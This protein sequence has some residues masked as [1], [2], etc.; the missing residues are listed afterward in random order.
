MWGMS[1]RPRL[2]GW[3]ACGVL[4]AASSV[5]RAIGSW[6]LA[7]PWIAPDEPTYGMLG[8]SLWQAGRL[9]ILGVEGPFYGLVYPAFA[10][11]PLTVL[12][13]AHGLRALQVIQP[14]VMST[15][16]LLVY[17]WARRLVSA[18]LALVAAALT[19]AVPAFTYS[20]LIM[21]EA[22][23]YPVATLA[24]LAIARA[25]EY[26]S[27]ARQAVAA[28]AILLAT[29]TR[30]Q[31]LVL[32]P[33]LITAVVL[34]AI[35]ERSTRPLRRF[36]VSLAL[37]CV[38][39]AIVLVVDHAGASKDVLG[40]YTTVARSSYELGPA[41]HWMVWHAADVF[42]LVAGVPFL[43]AVA[44]FVEAARGRE[45]SPAARALLAV[46]VASTV[47]L[48]AQVGVFSSRF[49]G[50][51][52][53][54]NLVT[55]APPLFVA[56]ALWLERGAPRPQPSTAVACVLAIVPA[57]A[58]PPARLTDPASEPS[59]FTALAFHHLHDWTSLDST[60]AVWVVAVA[61]LTSLFLSLP[62]RA[63][64]SLAGIALTLLIGASVV[65]S[66]DVHRLSGQLHRQLFAD[67][68]PRWIDQRADGPVAYLYGGNF[69]WNGVWM[70]VFWNTRIDQVFTLPEPLPGSLPPHEVVSPRFDGR[71][72]MTSGKPVDDP[73]ILASDRFTFVGT[74]IASIKPGDLS[75]LTLWSIE[76]P[77]RLQM[78]RTGIHPNGDISG[79]AQIELFSCTP[80]TLE[81]TLLGK[82]GSPITLSAPGAQPRT[83][84]P[85][86]RV[87]LRV[88]L[89]TPT[90]A[91]G[92]EPCTF[93]LDTPGLVGTTVISFVPAPS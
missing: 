50:I 53:E 12:G 57:L 67:A 20:G 36:A 75:R 92:N 52:I 46:T 30:L 44:L 77:V 23:Y 32:V 26:P 74:P 43:A 59:T 61:S 70:Y 7:A 93:S 87:G 5:G 83:F 58:L 84:A 86:P 33:V 56:F 72:F 51:L 18:R 60:R 28:T 69:Y 90:S 14:F 71:L 9:T 6:G 42:L 27:I 40:A 64:P 66:I 63:T 48:V 1:S 82:D 76:P 29:L 22:L 16:G 81:V 62:R 41:L 15:A 78:L 73:Y 91:T 2:A 39:G 65:A 68:G 13:P 45:S 54:R 31:G 37:L 47:L 10:G 8:R 24:L 89:R 19:L 85:A 49:A 21:T 34:L 80:G 4:V 25:L 17:A 79:H 38:A 35:F 3:G 88:V 55:V 11:V